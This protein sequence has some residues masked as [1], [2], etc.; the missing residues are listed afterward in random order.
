MNHTLIH[1]A[2]LL[3]VL[4]GTLPALTACTKPKDETAPSSPA[5][6]TSEAVSDT[7][8]EISEPDAP[9]EAEGMRFSVKSGFYDSAFHL[10]ISAPKDTEIYYTLDGSTPDTGSIRYTE[11]IPIKDR[12]PEENTLSMMKGIAQPLDEETDFLP[13]NPTE[14]T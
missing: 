1:K 3:L 6:E 8:T 14:T 5:A 4:L 9:F 7:D 12:S 11:P 13:L 10:A 2:E